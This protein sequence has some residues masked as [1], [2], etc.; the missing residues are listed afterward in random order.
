[1]VKTDPLNAVS[2]AVA[3]Y[4]NVTMMLNEDLL[5]SSP[6]TE[7]VPVFV[8]TN[9][10]QCLVDILTLRV[11]VTE[12]RCPHVTQSDC[13]FTTTVHKQVA[14]H[15]VELGCCY[16]FSQFLHVRWLDVDDI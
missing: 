5:H 12:S 9:K 1:M 11:S 3:V 16:H 2:H 4:K 13:T 8:L 10:Q 6:R 15:R 14:L 7:T